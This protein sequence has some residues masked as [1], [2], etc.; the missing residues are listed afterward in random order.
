MR[1][2]RINNHLQ[3]QRKKHA[4]KHRVI[5]IVCAQMG[6]TLLKVALQ[7]VGQTFELRDNGKVAVALSRARLGN[8]VMFV[9]NKEEST[10][11]IIRSSKTHN[12]WT[13]KWRKFLTF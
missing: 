6:D 8:D 5:A 11:Q 7:I 12:Q 4:L 10:N 3:A 9:G 2:Q 13:D 1:T